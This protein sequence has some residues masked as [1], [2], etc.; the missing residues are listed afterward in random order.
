M[1]RRD[2]SGS[3][4][5]LEICL[6]ERSIAPLKANLPRPGMRYCCVTAHYSFVECRSLL[7]STTWNGHFVMTRSPFLNQIVIN[8]KRFLIVLPKKML[9]LINK[10][11]YVCFQQSSL[12]LDIFHEMSYTCKLT[13]IITCRKFIRKIKNLLIFFMIILYTLTQNS[14]SKKFLVFFK[15]SNI[16]K[17]L[18]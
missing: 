6:H 13:I 10:L 11:N 14:V 12:Y 8:F 15:L 16:F 17:I 7:G 9:M 5:V 3:A 18:F 2:D 1:F 4:N